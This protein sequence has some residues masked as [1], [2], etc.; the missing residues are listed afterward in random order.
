MIITHRPE[1]ILQNTKQHHDACVAE[2][3]ILAKI[4]PRSSVGLNLLNLP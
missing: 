3:D 1:N 2:E 4:A